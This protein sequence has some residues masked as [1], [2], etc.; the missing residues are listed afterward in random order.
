MLLGPW[1]YSQLKVE[2]SISWITLVPRLPI[3]LVFL[4]QVTLCAMILL[5]LKFNH[6][7]HSP[8]QPLVFLILKA[9]AHFWVIR[10]EVSCPVDSPPSQIMPN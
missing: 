2:M 5:V 3:M 4:F 7:L 1:P 9:T 10:K 6:H 8:F